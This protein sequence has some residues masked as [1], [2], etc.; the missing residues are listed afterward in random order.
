MPSS[1]HFNETQQ[2]IN[3]SE[4]AVLF[5]WC[6]FFA[7]FTCSK[8]ENGKGLY[9]TDSESLQYVNLVKHEFHYLNVTAASKER[10]LSEDDC[11]FKCLKT[12]GC[13]SVNV[14]VPTQSNEIVL[15][16]LL[17]SDKY[18]NSKEFKQNNTS[19][20]L[21]TWVSQIARSTFSTTVTNQALCV[22]L[23]LWTRP[24][25]CM[26]WCFSVSLG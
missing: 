23:N 16:E 14:I 20:H 7:V 18:N 4:V 22:F 3:M 1:L 24:P 10:V 26:I 19:H 25:S 5:L 13:V 15:C 17:S 6:T 9:R 21:S 12:G 2:R 8:C 11:G